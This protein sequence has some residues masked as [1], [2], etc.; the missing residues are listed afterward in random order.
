MGAVGEEGGGQVGMADQRGHRGACRLG[1][2]PAAG[3]ER[4][5][6]LADAGVLPIRSVKTLFSCLVRRFS[7]GLP[8]RQPS[9][10]QLPEVPARDLRRVQSEPGVP[11]VV[12]EVAA[13]RVPVGERPL[14]A[15]ESATAA[16]LRGVSPTISAL[17]VSTTP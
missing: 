3:E 5:E 6:Y 2:A 12:A 1:V 13:T 14:R 10:G 4:G 9:C 11:A 16:P 15:D 8:R 17:P 7:S